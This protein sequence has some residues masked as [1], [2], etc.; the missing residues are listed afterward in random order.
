MAKLG[1]ALGS[2][3]RGQGFES[4]HSDQ[5]RILMGFSFFLENFEILKYHIA[6]RAYAPYL[7]RRDD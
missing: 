3:P 4:P 5:R 6:M 2:G 7:D 1:I